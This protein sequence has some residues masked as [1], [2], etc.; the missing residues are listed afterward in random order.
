MRQPLIFQIVG[1]KN[2]GKTTLL[3]KLIP[4]LTERGYRVG[5]VKH[6]AHDF[7]MD[8]EGKDTWRYAEAGAHVVAITS[9][10]KTAIL[11]QHSTP[12]EEL[13]EKIASVDIILVE[14][15]K[16]ESYPKIVLLRTEEHAELLDRLSHVVGVATWFDWTNPS[17]P[18]YHIDDVEKMAKAISELMEK[19]R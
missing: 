5:T 15:F 7:Q 9:S 3:C 19:R 6:D 12:L 10:S 8:H 14:G 11:E 2:T 13:V 16:N 4:K 17:L 1:F 18:A